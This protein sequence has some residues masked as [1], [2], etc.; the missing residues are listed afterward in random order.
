MGFVVL[1]KFVFNSAEKQLDPADS[2][3]IFLQ[4]SFDKH[5]PLYRWEYEKF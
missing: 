2:N 3:K 5:I 4:I 1:Y